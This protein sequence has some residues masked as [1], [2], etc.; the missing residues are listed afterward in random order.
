MIVATGYSRRSASR[1]CFCLAI[2]LLSGPAVF[3]D[4]PPLPTPGQA[5]SYAA[6]NIAGSQAYFL[7]ITALQ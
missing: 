7:E 6:K 5:P 1:Q 4:K 2:A 3:P